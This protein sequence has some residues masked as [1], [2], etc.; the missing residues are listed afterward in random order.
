[1]IDKGTYFHYVPILN[2]IKTI[3]SCKHAN[4][5][6]EYV[7]PKNKDMIDDE[8]FVDFCSGQA[9][10]TNPFFEKNPESVK[11]MLFQDAFEVVNPLGSAR[12]K[13]KLIAIYMSFG[14]LPPHVRTYR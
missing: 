12:S 13:Y 10:K 14:N 7:L 2:T 5:G 9:F 6:F 4:E 8:K 3:L 11:V 1:M